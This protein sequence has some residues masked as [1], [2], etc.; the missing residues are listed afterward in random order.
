[1]QRVCHLFDTNIPFSVRNFSYNQCTGKCAKITDTMCDVHQKTKQT[2]CTYANNFLIPKTQHE[3]REHCM[4]TYMTWG[5]ATHAAASTQQAACP[6]CHDC[7][8]WSWHEWE[9]QEKWWHR[10]LCRSPLEKS[11]FTQK[12]CELHDLCLLK[13]VASCSNYCHSLMLKHCL[14]MTFEN[15]YKTKTYT[16]RLRN[17]ND[18][19]AHKAQQGDDRASKI[20]KR[21]RRIYRVVLLCTARNV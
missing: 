2:I 16:R 20:N 11:I 17:R 8:P 4:D 3:A 18:S 19:T 9:L 21:W 10:H 15:L 1:M 6:L 13:L 14:Y 7:W 5:R 12:D